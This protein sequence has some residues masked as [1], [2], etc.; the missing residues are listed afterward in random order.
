MSLKLLLRWKGK[1]STKPTPSPGMFV[2]NLIDLGLHDKHTAGGHHI[3]R[4]IH[5]SNNFIFHNIVK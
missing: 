2:P 5:S 3:R 1:E 4:W